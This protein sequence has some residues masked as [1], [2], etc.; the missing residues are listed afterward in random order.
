[1]GRLLCCLTDL[2]ANVLTVL[3]CSADLAANVLTVLLSDAPSVFAEIIIV[4]DAASS[5]CRNRNFHSVTNRTHAVCQ[6]SPC[7][8][9]QMRSCVLQSG[10]RPNIVARQ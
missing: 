2:A 1:M 9:T 8:P 10:L 6:G 4:L 7:G 3:F 5:V